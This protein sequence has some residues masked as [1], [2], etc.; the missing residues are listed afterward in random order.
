MTGTNH[1]VVV[2]AGLGGLN[3]CEQ[4]RRLGHTGP[5]TLVGAEP[6]IPYDRPP[7][8]KKYLRAPDASLPALRTAAE[9]DALR[10]Q[11]RLGRKAVGLSTESRAVRLDDGESLPFDTLVIATGAVPRRLPGSNTAQLAGVYVLRTIEDADRLGAAI[12][13]HGELL[14]I[15]AGFIGSEVAAAARQLGAEV[16]VVEAQPAPLLRTTGRAVAE[17]VARLHVVNGVR[18]RCGAVVAGFTGDGRVTGLALGDGTHLPASTVLVALGVVPDTGWLAGSDVHIGDGVYCDCAGRTS[19]PGV[20]AVGDVAHWSSLGRRHE[21]WT[22]AVDQA[23]VV[24][25]AVLTDPDGPSPRLDA[26]PYFWSDLHGVRIQALGRTDGDRATVAFRAGNGGDQLVV[27]YG[28]AD[29]RLAGIVGF[30]TPLLVASAEQ[31]IRAH[32]EIAVAA[33]DLGLRTPITEPA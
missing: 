14:V 31:H 12:R 25:K 32:V 19:V 13:D 22:T 18:L 3:T 26:L 9:L 11:L 23:A 30:G 17:E 29:N 33:D 15:G 5:I 8:S 6:H 21:H 27:L 24:A 7:L 2:G 4:L 10:L 16:T 1:V 28:D 20:Y